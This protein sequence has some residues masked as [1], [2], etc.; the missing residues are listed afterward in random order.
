MIHEKT[1]V[2]DGRWA[3]VG[4]TNLNVASWL[5]NCEL[6]AIIENDKFARQMEEQYL[7][8]L[9][10]ATEIILGP[11][12]TVTA[13][14]NLRTACQ[15]LPVVGEAEAAIQQPTERQITPKSLKITLNRANSTQTACGRLNYT[16]AENLSAGPRV[17]PLHALSTAASH[18]PGLSWVAETLAPGI[19]ARSRS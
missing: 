17:H 9:R 14:V 11:R 7:A 18:C 1:A 2:A 15:Q 5:G 8:D 4:S 6:D 3:R 13:T 10:D 19:G 12:R 16:I